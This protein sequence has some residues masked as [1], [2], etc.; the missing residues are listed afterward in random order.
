MQPS[1]ESLRSDGPPVV[2]AKM[3][4]RTK[5]D[6]LRL[7]VHRDFTGSQAKFPRRCGLGT[8]DTSRVLTGA[9]HSTMQLVC[10]AT[11]ALGDIAAPQLVA[12]FLSDIAAVLLKRYS[13]AVQQFLR[14][15][16]DVSSISRSR[17]PGN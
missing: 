1:Y 12:V 15:R 4:S 5:Q 10:F 8:A 7:I 3:Q 14:R 11:A 16:G 13:A 9:R 6:A 17:S 2:Q